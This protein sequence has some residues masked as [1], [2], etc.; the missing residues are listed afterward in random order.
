[1]NCKPSSD[2][3]PGRRWAAWL[4]AAAFTMSLRGQETLV[5]TR[6]SATARDALFLVD[7]TAMS[8]AAVFSWPAGSKHTLEIAPWQF[9]SQPR[10][11]YSFQHWSTPSG[12]LASPSNRVTITADPGVAWYNA[13]V[14]TE[15]AVSL[16]FYQCADDSCSPPGTVWLN[17][18][19]YRQDTDVWVSAGS[20]ASLDATPGPGYVFA[21]WQNGGPARSIWTFILNSGITVYPHFVVA[22]TIR[23][24]TVP[25]GLQLLADRAPI[26]T[27]ATLDWGYNTVHTLGAISPQWDKVGHLWILRSWSDGGALT[28]AYE[29]QPGPAPV[30]LVGQFVPAVAVALLTDPIGLSL[31]VDGLDGTSPRYLSWAPEDRHTVTAPLQAT[32]AAGNAWAF[33]QWSNGA[34]NTQVVQATEAQ[35]ESGIRLTAVY[36]PLSRVRVESI[37]SGLILGV[38]GGDCRTPCEIQR[39]IG[40]TVRLSAPP[41]VPV[42]DGARL[43][44]SSWEGSDGPTFTASAGSRK[45]TAHYQTSY[46]L[47]LSTVPVGAG[48]WR[49]SPSSTDGYYLAGSTVAIGIDATSGT[50]FRGW[51][52]DLTGSANPQNLTMDAPHGVQGLFDKLPDQ[53]APPHIGNAAGDTPSSAVAPGSIAS[54]F[55]ADL[56]DSTATAAGDPLPQT[57]AGV[58]LICSGRLLPLLFVSPRQINFQVPGDL[59]PGP[60]QVELHRPNES[61]I[62]ISLSLTRNAPGLLAVTHQDGLPVTTDS[63]A[64]P[65][66]AIMLYSTGLGPYQVMPLDGFRVPSVPPLQLVDSVVVLVQGRIALPDFAVAL[67]GTVGIAVVEVQVPQD[68]DSTSEATIAVQSGGTTSNVMPLA[69]K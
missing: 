6:V 5:M 21:G 60:Y 67:A 37:P 42:A 31:S 55:G 69:L 49:L 61:V 4:L 12:Q 43:D 13:D 9:A 57:L 64:R 30:T 23:L 33:R 29:V 35:A 25:D 51:A 26:S 41:S 1:M 7:G 20:T 11:R 24:L 53:P 15:Y 18:V 50:K 19:A 40:S 2:F 3:G 39:A 36:D 63:P 38:D 44:F 54:I 59:P 28:H 46:R 34:P 66:E 58:T 14:S 16:N 52:Q 65:G 68:L 17:Q 8:G 27:P 22:R 10:T 56:S 47:S 62:R 48:F 32:D 45:V